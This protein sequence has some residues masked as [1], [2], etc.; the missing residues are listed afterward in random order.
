MNIKVLEWLEKNCFK[1]VELEIAFSSGIIISSKD[2]MDLFMLRGQ[3]DA[4]IWA[5]CPTPKI[6]EKEFYNKI[7]KYIEKQKID[8]IYLK[9]KLNRVRIIKGD[10]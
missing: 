6:K 9:E 10:A 5:F 3:L 1:Y 7:N 4:L 2:H 8:V